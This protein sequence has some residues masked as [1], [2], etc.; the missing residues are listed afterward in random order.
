MATGKELAFPEWQMQCPVKPINAKIVAF[1]Q[2]GLIPAPKPGLWQ[3]LSVLPEPPVAK[4]ED[5][6][7]AAL[8]KLDFAGMRQLMRPDS[9][10][11][12]ALTALIELGKDSKSRSVAISQNVMALAFTPELDP[13]RDKAEQIILER[14]V[15]EGSGDRAA[16]ALGSTYSWESGQPLRCQDGVYVSPHATVVTDGLGGHGSFDATPTRLSQ[17]AAGLLLSSAIE[18]A[19]AT[20][21]QPAAFLEAHAS[22]LMQFVDWVSHATQFPAMSDDLDP[23]ARTAAV[24]IANCP[25]GVVA[26]GVG[27]CT[28]LLAKTSPT[29]GLEMIEFTPQ[30]DAKSAMD[31]GGLGGGDYDPAAK[32]WRVERHPAGSVVGFV[33]GSDGGLPKACNLAMRQL[34]ATQV[35]QSSFNPEAT[36]KALL[37]ELATKAIAQRRSD[38]GP[39]KELLGQG[40]AVAE[41]AKQGKSK[42]AADTPKVELDD[43]CLVVRGV[44]KDSSR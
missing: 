8:K 38:M 3:F 17:R 19:I 18:S 23:E 11:F 33:A 34:F 6:L 10:Q 5:R 29:Q 16:L 7:A 42:P 43:V 14:G 26:F 44:S 35:T 28:A 4:P 30:R 41:M 32:K 36:L 31:V 9:P 13:E 21:K 12:V 24:A 22:E 20:Q 27:D 1:L 40:G 37:D 39:A 15:V 2:K 25:D